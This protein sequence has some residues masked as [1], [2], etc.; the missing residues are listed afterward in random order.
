MKI[1]AVIRSYREA[2]I[3]KSEIKK[4]NLREY[5]SEKMEFEMVDL[6]LIYLSN[7]HLHLNEYYIHV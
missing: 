4:I 7:V 2:Y 3:E 6:K 5:L 1:S